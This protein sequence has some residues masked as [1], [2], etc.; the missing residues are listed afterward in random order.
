MKV[1]G[2]TM[3]DQPVVRVAELAGRVGTHRPQHP[4]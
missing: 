2:V 4:L 1:L 3:A